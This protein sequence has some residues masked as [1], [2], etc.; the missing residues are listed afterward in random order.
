MICA[1]TRD[2][3]RAALCC[4]GL[5]C[6]VALAQGDSGKA[7]DTTTPPPAV[8]DEIVVQGKSP[9]ELRAQFQRAEEAVYD[10]F[11]QI[12]GNPEFDIHCRPET[13]TGSN[14]PRRVCQANFWRKAEAQAGEETARGLQGGSAFDPATFLAEAEYKRQLMTEK[15][16]RLAVSDKQFQ[17]ALV[18]MANIG[19]ALDGAARKSSVT[20]S[21]EQTAGEGPL[22]YDAAAAADVH[23]GREPWDHSLTQRTF[24]FAH[25][26]GKIRRLEV[27]CS[28]RTEQLKYHEGEEWTLPA[29]W[30]FC[31]LHV[32]AR[33]DTTFTLYEF[34]QRSQS[35]R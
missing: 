16:R 14:I 2:G 9:K 30:G 15:M 17:A 31:N 28:G 25:V 20:S 6:A 18:R 7:G 24:T 34:P 22:P 3:I 35:S 1:P 5:F 12:N 32:D 26:Y 29:D 11:N 4:S 33:R 13:P 21:V 23:I 8:G 19:Q 10:R 27:D